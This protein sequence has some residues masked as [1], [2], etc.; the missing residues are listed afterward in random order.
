MS[1]IPSFKLRR[2]VSIN[3]SYL[4]R[5][6]LGRGWEGEVYRVRE[7]YS[8]GERVLK[9]FDP[10][11]YRSKQMQQYCSKFD[12]IS[13]VEGIIHYYHGGYWKEKD[14]YYMVM[15]FFNGKDLEKHI[16]KRHFPVFKALKIVREIFRISSKCHKNKTCLGDIHL[17]NILM[18]HDEQIKIIDFDLEVKFTKDQSIIDIVSVCKLFYE[19]SGNL[20]NYP[21]DLRDVIPKRQNA[22]ANRYDKVT[23]VLTELEE[24]MGK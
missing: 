5:E 10:S 22:I 11:E 17:G 16:E 7:L 18:D 3:K 24:L 12:R 9:L 23:Q 1:V 4:I 21:P 19:L 20:D 2:G 8:D 6:C 14:A 13:S 15:E